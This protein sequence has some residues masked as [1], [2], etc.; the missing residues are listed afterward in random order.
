[1]CGPQDLGFTWGRGQPSPLASGEF[2]FLNF[3]AVAPF[4]QG[5]VLILVGVTL[6]KEASYAVLHG[7]QGCSQW[8]EL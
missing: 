7:H 3:K 2:T 5:D 8:G 6:F 4:L 1:M